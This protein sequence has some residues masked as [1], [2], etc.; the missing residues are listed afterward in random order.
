MIPFADV[1]NV[2]IFISN[3]QA[4]RNTDLT[5]EAERLQ[6]NAHVISVGITDAT[7]IE[8]LVMI[9][10]SP[11]NVFILED[12]YNLQYI[13][14]PIMTFACLKEGRP[15]FDHYFRHILLLT[16]L[17]KIIN[18][19]MWIIQVLTSSFSMKWIQQR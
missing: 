7:S 19:H 18:N 4:V 1:P 15:M 13:I 14:N 11:E 12:F 8:E 2:V 10:S 5:Q 6:K 9:A 3:G 17:S 16:W